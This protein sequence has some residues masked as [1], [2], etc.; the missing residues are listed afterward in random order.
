MAYEIIHA[1]LYPCSLRPG[2]YATAEQHPS[3][4]H[5]LGGSVFGHPWVKDSSWDEAKVSGNVSLR[6]SWSGKKILRGN[7]LRVI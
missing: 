5:N 1:L 7:K 2:K 4:F 6:A 3:K